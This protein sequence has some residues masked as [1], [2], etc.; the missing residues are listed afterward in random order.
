[1]KNCLCSAD[2]LISQ[3]ISPST[4]ET[5]LAAPSGAGLLKAVSP[6][7]APAAP[8]AWPFDA[9]ADPLSPGTYPSSWSEA[10][11]VPRPREGHRRR[12]NEADK[13]RIV[14]EAVQPGASLSAGARRYGIAAR[15]LFRW[16]QELTPPA[17]VTVQITDTD[18]SSSAA[19]TTEEPVL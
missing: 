11:I 4:S 5:F 13:H 8:M 12:F 15:V 7:A 2:W 3:T 19:P 14:E 18:A 1:M 6:A 16:K 10:P 17:F 9:G